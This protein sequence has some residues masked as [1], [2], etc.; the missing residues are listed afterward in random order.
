MKIQLTLKTLLVM[1]VSFCS[2]TVWGQGQGVTD[3]LTSGCFTATTSSYVNFEGVKVTSEAVYAGRT[4][5]SKNSDAV[6]MNSSGSSGIVTTSSGGTLTSVSVVWDTYT[7]QK[8]TLE[9]YGKKKAYSSSENLYSTSNSTKGTLIGS[10]T[11]DGKTTNGYVAIDEEYTYVGLRSKEGAIYLEKIEITYGGN[12]KTDQTLIFSSSSCT[13]DL[14]EEDFEEP[15]LSGAMT[16]VEYSSSNTSVAT[17]DAESG[18]VTLKGVGETTIKATATENDEY[19]AGSASYVLT[20]TDGSEVETYDGAYA[21]VAEHA[22]SCFAMEN[23]GAQTNTLDSVDVSA[24]IVNGKLVLP[25]GGVR[26]SISWIITPL[27]TSDSYT[28]QTLDGGYLTGAADN[29]SLSVKPEKCVWTWNADK[30]CWCVGN[31]SFIYGSASRCFKNFALSNMG[32]GGYAG[33]TISMPFTDGY[34]RNVASGN[35][36]TICLSYDVDAAD[37]KGAEF[38]SVLGKRTANGEVVSVLFAKETEGLKAGVPYVFRPTADLLVVAYAE[39]TS[40][41]NPTSANGLYGS[42]AGESVAEGM[43]LLSG[44]KIVKC[45]TGSKI[46]ANR[47]YINM[48]EVP[49]YSADSNVKPALEIGENGVVNSIDGIAVVGSGVVDVY[50]ISGVRLRGGMNAERALDGLA[51]GIYVVNGKKVVVK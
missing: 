51:K 13:A 15:T 25:A 4:A 49:E 26:N 11:Y 42:F 28:I 37:V 16:T 48:D 38:Y 36:G 7:P 1:L 33:A 47:A 12:K 24:N 44:N 39:G 2:Q 9:I 45:G 30:G 32:K 41:D 5:K 18:E 23:T 46:G 22:D 50:S 14:S 43:Y 20:V 31:R 29:T 40:V 10:I 6:Q 21:L 3:V 17:V 27:T 19:L 34:T 35:I 8:R